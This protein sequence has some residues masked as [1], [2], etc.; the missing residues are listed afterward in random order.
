MNSYELI[1][2][3]APLFRKNGK[4]ENLNIA[5]VFENK[6]EQCYFLVCNT[7][8]GN[9]LADNPYLVFKVTIPFDDFLSCEQPIDRTARISADTL[10]E[11]IVERLAYRIWCKYKEA[12]ERLCK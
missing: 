4:V 12:K 7:D 10:E 5:S 8:D 6:K 9:V 3:V 11:A 2:R 1:T